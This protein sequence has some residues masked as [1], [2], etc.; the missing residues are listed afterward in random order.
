[1]KNE[2]LIINGLR[3]DMSPDTRI[4][5]NFKSNLLGDVS[6]ITSS[7]SQTIQLPKTIRNRMIFDHASTPARNSSF[8]YQRHPAEYIRNGVK[9]ISD[10]YAVML[11]A[12]ENYE[13][14]LYWGEMTRFQQWIESGAK[15]NDLSFDSLIQI[16]SATGSRTYCVDGDTPTDPDV[17]ID[18]SYF[19]NADYDCGL[20]SMDTLPSNVRNQIWL[21]K[22]VSVRKILEKMQS[23]SGITFE[24]PSGYMSRPGYNLR[25]LFRS[26]AVALTTRKQF[27][28]AVKH[29]SNITAHVTQGWCDYHIGVR[30]TMPASTYYT[31]EDTERGFSFGEKAPVTVVKSNYAGRV[32]LVVIFVATTSCSSKGYKPDLALKMRSSNGRNDDYWGGYCT[33]TESLGKSGGRYYFSQTFVMSRA[34]DI[35]EGEEIY[36]GFDLS[37]GY[38]FHSLS[39][40]ATLDFTPPAVE[41]NISLGENF[42]AKGNFPDITQLDFVKAICGLFGL[43]VV[44]SG[45]ANKIKFATLDSVIDNRSNAVDWS[46][47]LIRAADGETD[48]NEIK[49]SFGDYARK[50]WFRYKDDDTVEASGDAP[51]IV[52]NETLE[53]ERDALTVPFVPSDEK[54][55]THT[56]SGSSTPVAAT[57]AV[58]PHYAMENGEIKDVAVNPRLVCMRSGGSTGNEA[59]ARF[60]PIS[61]D[62]MISLY[63]GQLSALLNSAVVLKER[64]RLTEFDLLN[65]DYSKP[66]FLK[67]YGRFYAIIS[68]QT[69]EE[70]CNVELLQL[71][72]AAPATFITLLFS[73]DNGSTWLMECPSN[74]RGTLKVKS[75]P[76]RALTP[77]DIGN[78]GTRAASS[79]TTR[80]MDLTDCAFISDTVSGLVNYQTAEEIPGEQTAA[81]ALDN[82][83]YIYFPE[84][85]RVFGRKTFYYARNVVRF[86]FPESVEEFARQSFEYCYALRS[87]E[88]PASV[89]S[90][91]EVAFGHCY[92]LTTIR[93]HGTTPPEIN[94]SAFH[95]AGSDYTSATPKQIFV[96]T[97]S[98][99]AYYAQPGIARIVDDF[100]FTIVEY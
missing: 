91:G 50:N 43:Y 83:G 63:Y 56:S 82:V 35:L 40:S 85:I 28:S 1:M 47:K 58:I 29:G 86:I 88:F 36:I 23:D 89:T 72:T 57:L 98:R 75:S 45:V 53:L 44:P 87:V 20:G 7:N 55:T 96:P 68:V 14:A 90:I 30:F 71:P 64:I 31:T 19:I 8:P 48:P 54:Q 46:S 67:Q 49:F 78:I 16:W 97:G 17:Y 32:E 5:L 60:L 92:D 61:F 34:F 51:L 25:G 22:F 12:S 3:V 66:V 26:V 74:W 4:V 52:E 94:Y 93:F 11:S 24:F 39:S 76:G 21:H 42:R 81:Y 18:D 80:R 6:K 9:I 99:S 62:N 79:G 38:R 77:E 10:A 2:E 41:S 13:I 69:A 65:L 15:L 70:Y 37:D 27:S 59:I 84:G 73:T 95:S 100:G 33:G